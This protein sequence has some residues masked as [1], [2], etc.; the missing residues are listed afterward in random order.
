MDISAVM[1]FHCQQ[2]KLLLCRQFPLQ[3]HL[4]ELENMVI[5]LRQPIVLVFGVHHFRLPLCC[6]M[7]SKGGNDLKYSIIAL[8]ASVGSTSAASLGAFIT[9][10]A[11]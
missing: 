4:M 6:L 3:Q 10:E 11:L 8:E 1:L 5:I 2:E 9:Q 7:F